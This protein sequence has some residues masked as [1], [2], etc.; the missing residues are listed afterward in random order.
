MYSKNFLGNYKLKKIVQNMNYTY[1]KKLTV[2]K[3]E[4]RADTT[5]TVPKVN[6][7]KIEFTFR[8]I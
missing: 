3:R 5:K 2:D 8:Y 6:G 7:A 4:S 1:H